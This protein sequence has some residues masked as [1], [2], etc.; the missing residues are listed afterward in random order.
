MS[1]MPATVTAAA[2]PEL[3]A[4]LA[5]LPP[6]GA[7][8]VHGLTLD[9][10]EV[11]AGV[12][13]LAVPGI[14]RDGRGFIP[15]ALARGAAAVLYEPGGGFETPVA[16]VPVIAVPEL[17]QRLGL[18]ADRF[19]NSP[20]R[21][22]C[23]IG[24]TGTNGK[25]TCTQLLAQALDHTESR[26]ARSAR[27]PLPLAGEGMRVREGEDESKPRHRCAI[28]GTL[29]NGYPGALEHSSHTTPDAVRLQALLADF[30][31]AG[32][33]TVCMEVSS[34][35]LEQGRVNGVRFA[36]ALLTNLTRDHLDYHLTLEAYAA[37]KQRLFELEELGQAVINVADPFG[38]ALAQ[39]LA[40]RLPVLTYG[41]SEGDVRLLDVRPTP[42]GLRLRLA[43]P[44]GEAT[45]AS[46]LLGRFNAEN[47]AAAFACLIAL[48]RSPSEAVER[49]AQARPPAGRMER[50]GGGER[51]LVIVDYAHSPDA[52]EK[53]LQ[54]LREHTA[55]RLLCVFGCGG[56][57]DRGKRPLMGRITELLA[58]EVILT[59][60]NP[61]HE[62]GA[63]IIAEIAA[64]MQA[65]P[66]IER[67]RAAAIGRACAAARAGDIVLVA[68]KGHEDYQQVGD[69][70]RPYSDRDTVRELLEGAA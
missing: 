31:R 33:V 19:Y 15:E 28:I 21:R 61:R 50:F 36:L 53:A 6:G 47:L 67:D 42:D 52:L 2:L 55:G 38:R 44:G 25:T 60:D 35:A 68:G 66:A 4:G 26:A 34:H 39:R 45:L 48:G 14:V 65:R 1:A 41:Y 59:D 7:I 51:P 57:R 70:R 11:R 16:G 20:S 49:L 23:V 8:A 32:A 40:G 27:L 13:F 22:L 69:V 5:P 54:A 29:G 30:A 37:A 43:A 64:G 63:A 18:I 58:D 24:V 62:D 46:P 17:R 9:S 3:L 56:E 10:R 12:V